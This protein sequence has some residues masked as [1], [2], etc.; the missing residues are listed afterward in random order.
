[1]Y[2]MQIQL[3]PTKHSLQHQ[4]SFKASLDLA[5]SVEPNLKPQNEVS[6]SLQPQD[7]VNIQTA[8]DFIE[9]FAGFVKPPRQQ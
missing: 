7:R 2:D 9:S 5:A 4:I 3:R 8:S 1:M 6:V